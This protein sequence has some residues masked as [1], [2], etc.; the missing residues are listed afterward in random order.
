MYGLYLQCSENGQTGTLILDV[1]HILCSYVQGLVHK[2]DGKLCASVLPPTSL[3]LCQRILKLVFS[4]DVKVSQNTQTNF[5]RLFTS[6][7]SPPVFVI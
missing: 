7:S 6:R 5:G 1:F 4:L 2:E 3:E